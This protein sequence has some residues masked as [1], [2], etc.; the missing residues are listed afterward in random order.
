[1]GF[2]LNKMGFPWVSHSIRWSFH[3]FPTQEDCV[4]PF[5]WVSHSKRCGMGF[6]LKRWVFHGF[7]TQDGISMGF[8][9]K[10]MGFPWVSHSKRWG[11]HGF[12]TQKD[13]V[14]MGFP[15][16][17]NKMGFPWVSHLKRWGFHQFFHGFATMS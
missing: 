13:A 9:L 4:F 10:K 15:L 7:P 1:M 3:G 17:L 11:F 12:P 8:P 6:Q 16:P 5:P 2:P 14:S